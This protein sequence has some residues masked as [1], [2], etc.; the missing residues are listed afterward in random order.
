[1]W[2]RYNCLRTLL[3]DVVKTTFH[4]KVVCK[5]RLH[6]TGIWLYDYIAGIITNILLFLFLQSNY[7]QIM[8]YFTR[9]VGVILHM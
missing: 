7:T 4:F 3:L 5:T 8:R 1:M 2:L 6:E 9:V